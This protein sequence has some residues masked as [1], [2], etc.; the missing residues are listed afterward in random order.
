MGNLVKERQGIYTNKYWIMLSGI[1]LLFSS[2]SPSCFHQ[3]NDIIHLL[4]DTYLWELLA[5][6]TAI[7]QCITRTFIAHLSC[8]QTILVTISILCC[9]LLKKCY[10][11]SVF[12]FSHHFWKWAGEDVFQGKPAG[13]FHWGENWQWNLKIKKLNALYVDGSICLFTWSP[14]AEILAQYSAL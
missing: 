13:C 6:L 12:C 10:G 4:L 9:K 11:K 3:E 1:L 5:V 8:C 14:P 2:P 7:S